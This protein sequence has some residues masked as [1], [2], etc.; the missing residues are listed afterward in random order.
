MLELNSIFYLKNV[1]H[2]V[3]LSRKQDKLSFSADRN[4]TDLLPSL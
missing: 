1:Q 2:D 4:F 3:F